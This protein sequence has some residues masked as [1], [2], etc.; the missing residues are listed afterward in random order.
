M[1]YYKLILYVCNLTSS[2]FSKDLSFEERELSSYYRIQQKKDQ[3][4]RRKKKVNLEKKRRQPSISFNFKES[5]VKMR[6]YTCVM[7]IKGEFKVDLVCGK[8]GCAK[9]K[10]K[11]GKI[12]IL[13]IIF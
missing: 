3:N 10:E 1:V 12:L 2:L 9:Q 4:G 7:R 8:C 11:G 6:D 13:D 5:F